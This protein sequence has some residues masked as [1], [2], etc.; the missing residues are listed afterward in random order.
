MCTRNPETSRAFVNLH[1][2]VIAVTGEPN[3]WART[4][5][6]NWLD[7]VLDCVS[8]LVHRSTTGVH[9]HVT[10]S[11]WQLFGLQV[12]CEAHCQRDN[13]ERRVL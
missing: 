1:G 13:R 5:P 3:T 7:K 2:R 11:P 10:K 6:G 12:I 4:S 8:W 9:G